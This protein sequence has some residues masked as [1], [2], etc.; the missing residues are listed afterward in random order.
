M[1][2]QGYEVAAVTVQ[3]EHWVRKYADFTIQV[4][5]KEFLV[6]KAMLAEYSGFFRGMFDCQMVETTS[7]RATLSDVDEAAIEYLI[8]CM[9][10][11]KLNTDK[12]PEVGGVLRAMD[13]LLIELDT[14]EFQV[15]VSSLIDCSNVLGLLQSARANKMEHLIGACVTFLAQN[16][17]EI[18]HSDAEVSGQDAQELVNVLVRSMPYRVVLKELV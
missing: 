12:I 11:G 3:K 13:R 17:S 5:E 1:T 15:A 6:H 9:Y 18:V 4:N 10:E 14:T 8:D 2:N 16:H 7:N